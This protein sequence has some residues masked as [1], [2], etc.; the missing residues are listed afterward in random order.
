MSNGIWYEVARYPNTFEILSRCVSVK[1]DCHD[2]KLN[3]TLLNVPFSSLYSLYGTAEYIDDNRN[4]N[5]KWSLNY[6]PE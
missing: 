1:Y 3:V 6:G 2:N 4:G 5:L